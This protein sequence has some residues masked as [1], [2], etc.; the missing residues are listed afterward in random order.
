MPKYDATGIQMVRIKT[1]IACLE[2]REGCDASGPIPFSVMDRVIAG[3]ISDW[4]WERWSV[5]FEGII[6]AANEPESVRVATDNAP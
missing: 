3:T 1:R 6:A 4:E 5:A 2:R